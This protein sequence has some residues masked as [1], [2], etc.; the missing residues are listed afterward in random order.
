MEKQKND[1]ERVRVYLSSEKACIEFGKMFIA[2]GFCVHIG[3]ELAPGTKRSRAYLE[4]WK[5]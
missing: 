4:Y 2:E 5:E 3:K 1:V